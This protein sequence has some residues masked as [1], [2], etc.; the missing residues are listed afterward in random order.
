MAIR[1]HEIEL[2]TNDTEKSKAFYTDV[3]GLELKVHQ[4]NLNV[5]NSGTTGI[6]FNTS[7]HFPHS[8]SCISFLTD[9]LDDVINKLNKLKATSISFN[10]PY[11]SHLGMNTI[12]FNDPDGYLIKVNALTDQSPDWMKV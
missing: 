6:D 7:T 10:G 5:F 12:S 11:S 3:L 8:V 2:G 9:D 4:L 1:L